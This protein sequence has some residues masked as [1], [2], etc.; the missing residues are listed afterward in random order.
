LR[1]ANNKS[2]GFRNRRSRRAAFLFADTQAG[3]AEGFFGY[4]QER[5]R[6]PKRS[7]ESGDAT[8]H[9]TIAQGG[10]DHQPEDD[11]GNE[12]G[13]GRRLA[14]PGTGEKFWGQ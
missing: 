12:N 3:Q 4:G 6:G 2:E 14:T 5:P 9:G 11:F 1:S 13:F 7:P 8:G 10:G